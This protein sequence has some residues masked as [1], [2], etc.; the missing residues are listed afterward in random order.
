VLRGEGTAPTPVSE[1][2]RC[3]AEKDAS[4]SISKDGH[5]RRR[6]GPGFALQVMKC[7]THGHFTVYPMGHVPYGRTAVAPVSVA[8]DPVR[9]GATS[10]PLAQWRQTVFEAS[11]AA[12]GPRWHRELGRADAVQ[13][14]QTAKAGSILGLSP[15]IDRTV[16]ER[17]CGA[18]SLPGLDHDKARRDYAAARGH[19]DRARAIV[20][21]LQ[22]LVVDGSFCARILRAGF[23]AGVWGRPL[24]LEVH[25]KRAFP[26]PGTPP[27]PTAPAARGAPHESVSDPPGRPP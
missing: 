24:V 13:R 7:E 4:C 26:S 22:L 12:S 25:T 19:L 3:P 10:T 11:A 6:T 18:L 17:I 16:A 20:P 27:L 14:R 9:A 5:R 15:D 2:V 21:L 8:G 1:R 23:L